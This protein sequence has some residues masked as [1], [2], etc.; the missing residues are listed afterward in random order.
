VPAERIRTYPRGI[1]V[2]RFHPAKRNGFY[3]RLGLPRDEIKLLYVGRVSREKNLDDL[4][5][6]F[7]LVA[8]ARP[9]ARPSVRLVWWA[10]AP[11]RGPAR[12]LAGRP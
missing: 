9:A 6:A 12:R 5:R 4:A 7:A 8:A 1:D 10:T 11:T 2:D 3:D